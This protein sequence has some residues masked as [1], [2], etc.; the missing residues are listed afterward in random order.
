MNDSKWLQSRSNQKSQSPRTT[1]CQSW[2]S[3]PTGCPRSWNATIASE[4]FLSPTLQIR[5]STE[6]DSLSA[7]SI[8]TISV[9]VINSWLTQTKS[10]A[11]IDLERLPTLLMS[12][13][14]VYAKPSL[15][16]RKRR[17]RAWM[18]SLRIS[19]QKAK[20]RLVHFQMKPVIPLRYKCLTCHLMWI[21]IW[22]RCYQKT[23]FLSKVKEW[24]KVRTCVIYWGSMLT[25]LQISMT[26]GIS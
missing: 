7:S 24:W 5:S 2:E 23:S 26:S 10:L 8:V 14:M 3:S 17:K 4:S 9:L 25:L 13:L 15:K 18:Q 16:R 6:H 21:L 1:R 19:K 20:N 22:P 12:H 11:R